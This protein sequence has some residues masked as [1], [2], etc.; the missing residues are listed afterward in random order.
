MCDFVFGFCLTLGLYDCWVS[1]LSLSSCPSE[2]VMFG[3]GFVCLKK[4]CL[5]WGLYVCP[6]EKVMFGMGFVRL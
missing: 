5:A 4:L 2:Q 3:M 6:S 1:N